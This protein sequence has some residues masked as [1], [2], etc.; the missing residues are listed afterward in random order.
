M[1]LH[2]DL[3]TKREMW[4]VKYNYTYIIVILPASQALYINRH[5]KA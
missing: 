5:D 1:T 2:C 4:A 3:Q